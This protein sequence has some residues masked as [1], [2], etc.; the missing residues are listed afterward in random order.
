MTRIIGKGQEKDPEAGKRMSD[1]T[2]SRVLKSAAKGKD[3]D[4][5]TLRDA[6]KAARDHY[7]TEA[8]KATRGKR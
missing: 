5:S 7:A 1:K 6:K 2:A 3:V 4:P 8:N